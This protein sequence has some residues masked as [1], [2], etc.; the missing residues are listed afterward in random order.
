MTHSLWSYSGVKGAGQG[1]CLSPLY[2]VPEQGPLEEVTGG[3]Q[4]ARDTQRV[5]QR[6]GTANIHKSKDIEI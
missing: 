1:A 4:R 6:A 5:C 2:R 3:K